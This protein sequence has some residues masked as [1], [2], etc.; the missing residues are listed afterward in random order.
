MVAD[1]LR[2]LCM[3]HKSFKVHTHTGEFVFE[4]P[5]MPPS[6]EKPMYNG[7]RADIHRVFYEYAQSLGV[8]FEM[9]QRVIAY[10]EDPSAGKSWVE[11]ESGEKF[12]GHVVVGAD[13]VRSRARKL[14]LGLDDATK[15]SGYAVYRAW[16]NAEESGISTDPLTK[17]FVENGD[18]HTGW[19]GE[20]VHL[21]VA[22][23]KGG[24]EISWVCTHR[25]SL[26]FY[27]YFYF[28]LFCFG[29][30]AGCCLSS[31]FVFSFIFCFFF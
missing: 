6:R 3:N 11:T 16:F 21:L 19:L 10:K 26:F 1:K 14:V 22:S 8:V 25:V 23:C 5:A 2:P 9:G 20:N 7:H 17:E 13:G 12:E 28:F 15:S 4:Q 31:F 18:T 29:T 24:R 27:F 30:C